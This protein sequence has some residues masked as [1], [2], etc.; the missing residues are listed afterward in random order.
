MATNRLGPNSWGN[1]THRDYPRCRLTNLQ[2]EDK[3]KENYKPF[4]ITGTNSKIIIFKENIINKANIPTNNE[5][6]I[7]TLQ[8]KPIL[9]KRDKY[10]SKKYTGT[11]GNEKGDAHGP[12]N[13]YDTDNI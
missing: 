1:K 3:C 9:N 11:F 7:L 6:I 13:P 2:I 5:R 12:N 10:F 4:K 8:V